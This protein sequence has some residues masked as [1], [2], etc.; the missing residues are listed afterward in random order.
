M[1]K[2]SFHHIKERRKKN[3]IWK[4]NLNQLCRYEHVKWERK[5]MY[6]H[7]ITTIE[8]TMT[9]SFSSYA[10]EMWHDQN[11][12]M[13]E[14][15]IVEHIRVHDIRMLNEFDVHTELEPKHHDCTILYDMT[16]ASTSNMFSVAR[17]L[18]FWTHH[19]HLCHRDTFILSSIKW[20]IWSKHHNK[21]N[22]WAQQHAFQTRTNKIHHNK[23][24]NANLSSILK[25]FRYFWY[26]R[27]F[28]IFP[29][30]NPILRFR[31]N[32]CHWIFTNFG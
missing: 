31:W 29:M 14:M 28:S 7:K 32:C 18:W 5:K 25:H 15:T 19:F 20:P 23:L 17:V 11:A 3:H 27:L 26:F 12:I 1:R 2:P 6:K 16:H 10:G 8:M 22:L 30:C 4:I 24:G 21:W 9:F 13:L